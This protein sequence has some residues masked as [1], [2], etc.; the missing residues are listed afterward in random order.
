MDT[1]DDEEGEE[2]KDE[3]ML[4]DELRELADDTAATGGDVTLS[5]DDLR[6]L[7]NK[8]VLTM[9]RQRRASVDDEALE[10]REEVMRQMSASATIPSKFEDEVKG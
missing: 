10:R 3:G 7:T 4:L 2:G 6:C 1:D 9:K 8:V 5:V